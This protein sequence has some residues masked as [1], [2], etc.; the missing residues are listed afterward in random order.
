VTY[1]N[2]LYKKGNTMKIKTTIAATAATTLAL[3]P[4]AYAHVTVTPTESPADGY[5][6]LQFTG[7]HG[8]DGSST[9]GIRV[10]IPENVPSA[11][12]QVHPGWTLSTKEGPKDEVE[13]F[14]E[15][16]TE[17]VSEVSWTADA[18][19]LPD[20]YL[21]IFSIEVK[22]PA[23]EGEQIAFPVIQTCQKG[24]TRWIEVAGPGETEEDLES[25]APVV[26]LTAPAED[27]HGGG[28]AD[29]VEGS[30]EHDAGT[31]TETAAEPEEDD[32]GSDGLAIAGLVLGGLGLITGGTALARSRSNA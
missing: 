25:P 11:T 26:A 19:P 22:L 28:G 17:G 32:G 27:A 5:A 30:E 29:A 9:T 2:C 6:L 12:P 10:Q 31:E 7:P 24:E 18:E 8:C 20:D 23:G 4:A 3:V 1:L 15:T 16:I 21:D 13:L 14:G